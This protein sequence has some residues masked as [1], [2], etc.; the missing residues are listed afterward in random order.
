MIVFSTKVNKKG[1]K[2]L[3]D[4]ASFKLKQ[5]ESVGDFVLMLS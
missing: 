1:K 3:Y 2:N 5:H 4:C